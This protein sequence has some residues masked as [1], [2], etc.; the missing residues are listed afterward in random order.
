MAKQSI[1]ICRK[2]RGLGTREERELKNFHKKEYDITHVYCD[3][4]K[5]SGREVVI[6]KTTF[7]P[8]LN[9]E[10]I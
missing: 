10:D 7:R 3:L 6:V 8:Y 2:C 4:C 5:G 1:E 9:N